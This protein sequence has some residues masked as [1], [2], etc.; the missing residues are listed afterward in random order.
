MAY[1][2]RHIRLDKNEPFY[3]GIGNSK[4]NRRAYDNDNRNKYWLNIVN[5]TDYEVEI[6]FDDISYDEAKLKEIEFISLYGRK[7]MGTGCLVNMTDGG[8]GCLNKIITKETAEK[9]GNSNR[10]KKRSEELKK[11]WSETQKKRLQDPS[12]YKKHIANITGTKHKEEMSLEHRM[13]IS[14]F[15]KNK[16]VSEETKVRIS[17]AQKK[18]IANNGGILF[19]KEQF[20]EI[21][22]K[23][24]KSSLGK[25]MS[26]QAKQKMGNN[27][28]LPILQYDLNGIFVKEWDG[29]VDAT[30]S[31][32]GHST[33]IMRC[34]QG[35]FKQAYGFIWKYKHPEKMGRK[36]RKQKIVATK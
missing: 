25:K 20:I 34:C 27:Q 18:R 2:Y 11:Q 5:M 28:K 24:S 10:G 13:K 26:E 8:D 12:A 6:L 31:I 16:V 21:C 30:K 9:I 14:A 23:I 22:K 35:K 3:I 7:D 17:T 32:G 33:N 36:P 15:Q 29:I 1:L 4:N 19:G